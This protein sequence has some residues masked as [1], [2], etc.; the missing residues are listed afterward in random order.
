VNALRRRL[1]GLSRDQLGRTLLDLVLEHAG[2]LLGYGD[3][4][5]IEPER[6]FLESGFD[7]LTAVELRNRLGAAT[8]LRLAPTVVFD[9]RTPAG[10]AAH[11]TD[12]LGTFAGEP[13]TASQGGDGESVP[14]LFR[15]MVRAGRVQ[16]GLGMLQWVAKIRPSFTSR[17]DIDRLPDVVRL[18]D[19]EQ[20]PHL[21]CLC[22]PA[23]MGGV[24]QYAKIAAQ[25]QGSHKVS[26]IAMPGFGTGEQLPETADAVLDVLAATVGKTVG[27]APYV[28]LG[29]SGGGLFAHAVAARI[30]REHHAPAGAAM[31]DT[32][33][34]SG[35]A[36]FQSFAA[37]VAIGALAREV[38]AGQ[39]G[40]KTSLSAMARYVTLMPEIEVTGI[41]TPTLLLHATDRFHTDENPDGADGAAEPDVSWRST[42]AHADKE[43]V[44]PG[45]HFSIVEEHADTTA[46]ALRTWL[47]SLS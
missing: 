10:L 44:I 45:D 23:A 8:G 37:E 17:A 26:V 21:V 34:L 4:E 24:Y 1:A 47:D 19:G 14:E 22:T 39:L 15:E 46:A 11:L 29:H 18:S 5:T 28:L 41:A 36:M 9:H 35:D 12:E 3:S 30:V 31:L 25:F 6:H 20:A 7:S 32:Y 38:W 2:A 33:P 27:D 13:H 16:E 42:W 40:N 43:L